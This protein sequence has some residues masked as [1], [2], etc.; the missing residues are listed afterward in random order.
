MRVG[1]NGDAAQPIADDLTVGSAQRDIDQRVGRFRVDDQQVGIR[2]TGHLHVLIV[3]WGPA[4]APP[5]LSVAAQQRSSG[6]PGLLDGRADDHRLGSSG[7]LQPPGLG[8]RAGFTDRAQLDVAFE[9]GRQ[10][11]AFGAIGGRADPADRGDQRDRLR[12]RR[13][14]GRDGPQS[15]CGTQA[16]Q[17]GRDHPQP[18]A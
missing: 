13:R 8:G 1:G 14:F 7:Q 12:Q 16:E 4:G 3:Q 6:D 18:P 10:Q 17:R 11:G 15:E 9:A 5:Q 2:A